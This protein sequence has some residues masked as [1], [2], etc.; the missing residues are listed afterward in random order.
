MTMMIAADFNQPMHDLLDTSDFTV[1][2]DQ[3][4]FEHL[5]TV[6]EQDPSECLELTLQLAHVLTMSEDNR[7]EKIYLPQI[8]DL[9]KEIAIKVPIKIYP[10][11]TPK[12]QKHEII[13]GS[14]FY[15]EG[16]HNTI[17]KKFLETKNSS[18][19]RI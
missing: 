7:F 18:I 4:I 14:E 16:G 9:L 5:Y 19:K 2:L 12:A 1:S 11:G 10:S 3:K 15:V 13:I 17:A 6:L 8:D